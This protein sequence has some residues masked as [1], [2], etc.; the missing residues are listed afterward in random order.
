MNIEVSYTFPP[1]WLIGGSGYW[2]QCHSNAP[3]RRSTSRV[4]V[5]IFIYWFFNVTE[6][7]ECIFCFPARCPRGFRVY[8]AFLC[9]FGTSMFRR[10]SIP[11][12]RSFW[13]IR[14]QRRIKFFYLWDKNL[15]WIM[16]SNLFLFCHH[17]GWQVKQKFVYKISYIFL[18]TFSCCEN[19]RIFLC[20]YI[21]H[22]FFQKHE[23]KMYFSCR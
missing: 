16:L 19:L 22:F 8:F 4:H 20:L 15:S 12:G 23:W 18:F 9:K 14:W 17:E 10:M 7:F 21:G 3:C 1:T 13:S 6:I 11:A 5:R 2:G